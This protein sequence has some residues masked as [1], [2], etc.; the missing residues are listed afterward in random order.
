MYVFLLQKHAP[1]SL[2][3]YICILYEIFPKSDFCLQIAL[4][5]EWSAEG[6]FRR[7]TKVVQPPVRQVST[8]TEI[9]GSQFSGR[10]TA[11]LQPEATKTPVRIGLEAS[12]QTWQYRCKL[13]STERNL[14]E[15]ASNDHLLKLLA[16]LLCSI[17]YYNLSW[18]T[19][20]KGRDSGSR[21][22][23]KAVELLGALFPPLRQ[24]GWDSG[25][26]TFNQSWKQF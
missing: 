15:W 14:T 25:S 18:S 2:I 1:L 22:P 17:W 3:S 21:V 7:G 5:Y 24:M 16:R 8:S 13:S 11:A 20:R 12:V 23:V 10:S 26:N 19:A 6:S 4:K 9:S